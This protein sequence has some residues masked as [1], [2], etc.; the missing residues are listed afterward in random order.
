M[1][2]DDPE[3]SADLDGHCWWDA[4]IVE[5]TLIAAGVTVAVG[6]IVEGYHH[7]A[8]TG[9]KGFKEA[10]ESTKARQDLYD[11]A[12]QGKET[13]KKQ[14]EV[15]A[16]QKKAL[17]TAAEATMEGAQLPGTSSGGDVGVKPED[18]AAGVVTTV[19]VGAAVDATRKKAEA[20]AKSSNPGTAPAN[21]AKPAT[22]PAPP[23]PPP[24]PAP[25]PDMPNQTSPQDPSP[26]GPWPRNSQSLCW[27]E[28]RPA[29]WQRS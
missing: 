2:S 5:Y 10:R 4:C 26:S 6:L 20:Q 17:K 7:F 16:L 1:V 24:P 22:Q 12:G 11:A 13:D 23:P 18:G 25:K 21:P 3:T 9:D 8:K 27:L 29:N 15:L 19:T 28:P 14:D